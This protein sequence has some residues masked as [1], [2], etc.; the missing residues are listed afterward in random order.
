ME[1]NVKEKNV[2]IKREREKIRIIEALFFGSII[3][4]CTYAM[5]CVKFEWEIIDN[6]TENWMVFLVIIIIPKMLFRKSKLTKWLEKER[7]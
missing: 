1:D 3:I 6:L 5:L 7:W 4:V 2:E